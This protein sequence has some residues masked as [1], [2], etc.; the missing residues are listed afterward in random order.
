MIRDFTSVP[1]QAVAKLAITAASQVMMY[2]G[3]KFL[4][5]LLVLS[6]K[7]NEKVIFAIYSWYTKTD[8]FWVFL[9]ILQKVVNEDKHAVAH[10]VDFQI[11]NKFYKNF[12]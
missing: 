5:C 6:Y 3:K 8:N 9:N 12:D 4:F 10:I 7:Q 11:L 2:F 1:L